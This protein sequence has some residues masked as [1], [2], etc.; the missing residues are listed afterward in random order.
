MTY[1]PTAY[2]PYDFAIDR[3]QD[4]G[5]RL[6]AFD[7]RD[8]VALRDLSPGLGQF[9]EH[10]VAQL[11]RRMRRDPHCNHP[12][13]GAQP[14]VFFSIFHGIS[15]SVVSVCNGSGGTASA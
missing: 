1:T 11:L 8:L 3:R 5:R 14:F 13:L 10:H 6:D 7:H 4:V 12:A 15:L 2:N 9:D